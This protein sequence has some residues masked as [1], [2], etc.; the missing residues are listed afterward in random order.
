MAEL[1]KE[2]L[3]SAALAFLRKNKTDYQQFEEKFIKL[4]GWLDWAGQIEIMS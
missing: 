2:Y 3:G 1:A 4:L